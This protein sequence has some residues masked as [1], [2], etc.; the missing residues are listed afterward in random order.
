MPVWGDIYVK[1][2]LEY[3]LP[4]Q[5]ADNNLPYLS[6]RNCIIDYFIYTSKSN[7]HLFE[8][9]ISF[10]KLKDIANVNFEYI[11]KILNGEQDKYYVMSYSHF[12]IITQKSKMNDYMFLMVADAIYSNSFFKYIYD[13]IYD[14]KKIVYMLGFRVNPSLARICR[15]KY[16]NKK[17]NC[18]SVDSA[19]LSKLAI[20]HIHINSKSHIISE[21]N[22]TNWPSVLIE[23]VS[24]GFLMRGFH[25]H[26]IAI[27]TSVFTKNLEKFYSIDGSAAVNFLDDLSGNE[28][29]YVNNSKYA[30]MYTFELVEKRTNKIIKNGEFNFLALASWMKKNAGSDHLKLVE[31]DFLV[32]ISGEEIKNNIRLPYYISKA[33]ELLSNN[34]TFELFEEAQQK[35]IKGNIELSKD[36]LKEIIEKIYKCIML[37]GFKDNIK[38]KYDIIL[39]KIEYLLEN[40]YEI[41]T[42]IKI[43]E[44]LS[45]I[46]NEIGEGKSFLSIFE[47]NEVF[48]QKIEHLPNNIVLYGLGNYGREIFFLLKFFRKNID[49]IID[50]NFYADN[51]QGVKVIKFEELSEPVVLNNYFLILTIQKKELAIKI[52]LKLE[53]YNIN[54]FYEDE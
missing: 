4:S 11:D 44:M 22:F 49:F 51:Y 29:G 45:S 18:I 6:D 52:K 41:S 5:L 36:M 38:N 23:K 47:K 40:Y 34:I 54:F 27:K 39:K 48:I 2:F 19:E 10:K 50:D 8:E 26:P 30:S 3:S 43:I 46:L 31:K 37:L 20:K 14:G 24:N 42:F 1:S 7:K 17:T 32:N 9:S 28:I 53:K 33:K 25:L 21:K 12:D 35:Y 13:L 16:Y 15:K